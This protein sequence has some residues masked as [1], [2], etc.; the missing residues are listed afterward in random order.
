M[1][2]KGGMLFIAISCMGTALAMAFSGQ[3]D[4]KNGVVEAVA[5]SSSS[6]KQP[7]AEQ[8]EPAQSDV[9]F[10]LSAIKRT[11]PG[12]T[13]TTHLFQPKSWYVP[14]PQPPASTLPPP[15]PTAPLLSFTYIGKMIN[16]NEVTLFLYKN[17]RQYTVKANDVLDDSYRVDQITDSSV[18]LTYLPMN[19]QQTLN[20]NSATAGA[21]LNSAAL[22]STMQLPVIPQIQQQPNDL[23]LTR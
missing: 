17:D 5:M 16:G 15:Q 11:V 3:D 4:E 10:D 14:P 2:I 9:S 6:V 1:R 13:K 19:I 7:G 23:L 21:S 18:V 12:N 22:S 8:N 20:I